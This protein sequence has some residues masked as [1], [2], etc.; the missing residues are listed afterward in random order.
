MFRNEVA[1]RS[2]L[3]YS[4]LSQNEFVYK[5]STWDLVA[6]NVNKRL[7]VELNLTLTSDH[8]P[9][10]NVCRLSLNRG[11]FIKIHKTEK[12]ITKQSFRLNK[13]GLRIVFRLK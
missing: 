2:N 10:L 4:C 11:Q 12:R 8:P 13:T 6:S 7:F 5:E 1:G 9:L 3:P